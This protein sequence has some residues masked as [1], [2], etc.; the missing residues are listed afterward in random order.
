MTI[1]PLL[2]GV[3]LALAAPAFA[4][5]PA[6]QS[7]AGAPGLERLA[8]PANTTNPTL[9][10]EDS[11]AAAEAHNGFASGVPGGFVYRAPDP[12]AG[13][14]AAMPDPAVGRLLRRGVQIKDSRGAVVGKVSRLEMDPHSRT[15]GVVVRV[16]RRDVMLPAKELSA[17]GPYLV[18]R[19]SARLGDG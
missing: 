3:A 19:P 11:P 2:A 16:G 8:A 17:E 13:L 5:Q 14:A 4:Q 1:R 10:P 7:A 15:L 12:D 6:A 18:A 9:S